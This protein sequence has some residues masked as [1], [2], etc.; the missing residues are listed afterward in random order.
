MVCACGCGWDPSHGPPRSRIAPNRHRQK[1]PRLKS[2]NHQMRSTWRA[3]PFMERRCKV[4]MIGLT[5]ATT[6]TTARVKVTFQPATRPEVIRLTIRRPAHPP[7]LLPTITTRVTWLR[8]KVPCRRLRRRQPAK[9]HLRRTTLRTRTFT[10]RNSARIW[11]PPKAITRHRTRLERTT[12]PC[13]TE[14]AV[15]GVSA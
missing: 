1:L 7:F 3:D 13:N 10:R 14:L 11:S 5:T 8:V 4:K 9:D 12:R 6:P 2:L 15:T